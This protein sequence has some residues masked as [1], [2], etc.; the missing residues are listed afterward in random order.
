[1]RTTPCVDYDDWV[2]KGKPA[3]AIW[4]HGDPP[5]QMPIACPCG[6]G[7]IWGA[8]FPRWT[9]DGNR[10]A[11]TISPSLRFFEPDGKTT[12]WHGFIKGGVFETCSDSP[13]QPEE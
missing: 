3:G 5:T 7:G 10:E 1:M 8:S 12:H 4:F 11:P 9:F 6:C 13:H 2:A